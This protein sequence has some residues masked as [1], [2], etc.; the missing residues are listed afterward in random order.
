MSPRP[1]SGALPRRMGRWS[2][3]IDPRR[4]REQGAPEP[5]RR[6]SGVQPSCAHPH[7]LLTRTIS[8]SQGT[9]E[10]L[11]AL[12]RE[13]E[14]ERRRER[15][16]G[17]T[18]TFALSDRLGTSPRPRR[19]GALWRRR[20]WAA[21]RAKKRDECDLGSRLLAPPRINARLPRRAR[22]SRGRMTRWRRICALRLW[23][24]NC[25]P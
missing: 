10:R 25:S 7:S 13:R 2:R 14:G 16:D 23:K 19:T 1:L 11:A 17:G 18:R 4:R 3:A 6:Y 8:L 22:R 5:G 9:H 12:K 15:I 20:H 21:V 24:V